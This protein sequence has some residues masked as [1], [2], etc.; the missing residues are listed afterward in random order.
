MRQP[1]AIFFTFFLFLDGKSGLVPI[2]PQMSAVTSLEFH[3]KHAHHQGASGY[4]HTAHS[5]L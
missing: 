1:V 5:L 4:R 3:G 2:S